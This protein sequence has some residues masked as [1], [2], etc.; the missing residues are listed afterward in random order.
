MLCAAVASNR[1]CD[2]AVPYPYCD[3]A[4]GA[5]PS[6]KPSLASLINELLFIAASSVVG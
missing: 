1:A 3:C 5:W 6:K 4:S 2:G